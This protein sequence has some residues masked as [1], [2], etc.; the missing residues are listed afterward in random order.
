MIRL[1]DL[2]LKILSVLQ[3]EGRI[4][5]VKLAEAV[6]LSP[7][8]CWERLKRLEDHGVISGYH[9]H[10][11]PAFFAR[12]T[13]VLTEI[14]LRQ[15]R[16]CDFRQFEDYICQIPE[17]VECFALGG[18]LDYLFKVLC[19]DVDGYQRLIDRLLCAEIGID[20]YFT[21]IVTKKIKTS[22]FIPLQDTGLSR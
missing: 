2:D 7:S 16:H 13:I 6:N 17:I 10:I 18:G 15:H 19:A 22:P 4:T 1:D 21:Y 11:N 8:P 5:K 12:Q 14:K 9:A 3:R 20:Q